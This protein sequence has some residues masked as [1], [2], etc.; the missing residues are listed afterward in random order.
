[1]DKC[2]RCQTVHPPSLIQ[3]EG[4]SAPLEYYL[5]AY[6]KGCLKVTWQLCQY[7]DDA[8]RTSQPSDY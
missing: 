3:C 2:S 5:T 6:G 1:M 4:C 7:H 8:T